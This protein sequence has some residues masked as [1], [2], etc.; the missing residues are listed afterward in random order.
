M[1]FTLEALPAKHGDCLILHF[2]ESGQPQLILIDGGPSG[3][4]KDAL[5]PRLDSLASRLSPDDPLEIAVVM[6]S[7]IDDDHI[8]G[9][10][11]LSFRLIENRATGIPFDVRTLWLNAFDDLVGNDAQELAAGVSELP[12]QVAQAGVA[13]ATWTGEAQAVVASVPQ[14]RD[15]RN[16]ASGL[17]WKRND[18]FE[19]FVLAPPT[20]GS[21]ITLGQL[22]LTVVCPRLPQLQ[23]LQEE[24]KK[25]L[26]ELAN[27]KPA[28]VAGLAADIDKSVYNMSSIVCLAELAGKRILLTGDAVGANILDGLSAADKLDADGK[29]RVDVLKLP[30]HGSDRNVDEKFFESIIARHY[31]VSGDGKYNN[32][33]PDTFRL[34]SASRPDNEFTVHFTYR[35]FNGQVGDELQ[36]LFA[37]EKQAGRSYDVHFRDH[38]D[39]SVR[40]DLLDAVSY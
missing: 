4:Y 39:Q 30:H 15:L 8:R 10:L 38:K 18:A 12:A 19:K 13:G 3:V 29:I 26:L 17:G 25:K 34:I 27:A 32:P 21:Q 11:D 2:G 5:R 1:I 16:N 28:D 40:I 37:A 31:V 23:A 35:D 33:E 7:H 14:G 36:A 24:W 22:T 20:G 6:V 9:I